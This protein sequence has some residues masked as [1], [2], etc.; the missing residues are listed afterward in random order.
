MKI[1]LNIFSF[2]MIALVFAFVLRIVDIA[3]FPGKVSEAESAAPE[4]KFE[5]VAEMAAAEKT[6]H[7]PSEAALESAKDKKDEQAAADAPA[8]PP[9]Y[10][11]QGYSAAEVEMLQSLSKRRDELDKREQQIGAREA[12]LKAAG[13]EVDRKIAELNKIRGQLEDLLGK[14]KVAEDERINS[15]VKIY[16][17]MKPKDAAN[18]FN[19]L[20]MEVLLPVIGKMKEA[21]ASPVLAAM[22]AD[23]A[24]QVTIKLAE[25]RKLPSL[26]DD[27]K[28]KPAS[29]SAPPP[30]PEKQ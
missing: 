23:K 20:D 12:L 21:K 30:L 8:A 24:R 11:E 1:K 19:T 22:D 10:G 25:Q 6:E 29:P 5:P 2:L 14:Q 13:V 9:S 18:I 4:K 3:T 28:K 26:P 7:A 17:G 16:E 27:A 15:L